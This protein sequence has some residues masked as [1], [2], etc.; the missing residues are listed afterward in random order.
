MTLRTLA[1]VL[2]VAAAWSAPTR[3]ARLQPDQPRPTFRT[4]ANYVRV[5]VFPTKDGVPV[6]DLTADDFEVLEDKVPQKIDAFQH[7]VIRGGVPSDARREPNSVGESR[8]MARETTGRTFVIFLD[9]NHVEVEGSHRIRQPVVNALNGAIGAEDMVAVMTPEMSA[10]DITFARR[11]TTIEGMLT[12]Y[13]TWGERERLSSKDPIEDQYRACYPGQR[14]QCP[15][16]TVDDNRGVYAEMIDRRREKQTI[17][18]LED[19]VGYL[20]DLREERKAV[21]VVTDGWRLFRPDQA[22]TRKLN[23]QIPMAQ[24]YVDPRSG[25][26]T[27]KAPEGPLGTSPDACAAAH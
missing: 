18:A 21:F 17:D 20:R 5:D 8:A 23:C 3:S 15:D 10:R 1:V 11:T 22:L 24:V 26:P 2:A 4:E 25:K 7:I 19:L 13:W 16:G 14:I 9:V 27:T 12:R 6:G